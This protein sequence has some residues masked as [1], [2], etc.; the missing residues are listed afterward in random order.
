MSESFPLSTLY[1]VLCYLIGSIPSAYIVVKKKINKDIT[2]E[3]SGNVGTLNAI[4]VTKS[5]AS[6]ILVLVIDLLKGLLPA[7]ILLYVLHASYVTAVIGSVLVLVGHNYPIW[8]KF[9]GG[10]GLASGAGVF[11]VLNYFML[12][13]WGLVWLVMKLFK[14]GVLKANAIATFAII[15]FLAVIDLTGQFIVNSNFKGFSLAAFNGAV[16]AIAVLILIKH[17]EAIKNSN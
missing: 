5:K 6:G 17:I 8:L 15:G 3:G 4:V 14:A 12:A 7:G 10:R 13:V 1:F 9:R 2:K 11:I 16:I